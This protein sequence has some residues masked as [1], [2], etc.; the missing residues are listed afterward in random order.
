MSAQTYT[1]EPIAYAKTPYNQKFGIS[2]QPG[3][4]SASY[5]HIVLDKQFSLDAVRGLEE[6]GRIWVQFVFHDAIEE[7][8]S[9]LV[10]PPRLGGKTKKGVFSTRS[11]HRPNHLGLSLLQLN[12]IQYVNKQVVLICAGSDLLN[13]TPIVDIK[14]YIPFVE[15]YPETAS[16]FVDGPPKMLNM[17][18]TDKA[19]E[20]ALALLLTKN[21]KLLIEQSIAQDPR[22]AYQNIPDRI[23]VMQIENKEIKFNIQ[24]DNAFIVDL[25]EI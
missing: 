23:Y 12:E 7:G 14:P 5:T 6:F 11:P 2:R 24:E 15:A 17:V 20:Q 22:P 1:I 9:A 18:W 16:G 21:E 8:W 25:I 13:N 19:S 10:R 3:I 4:V